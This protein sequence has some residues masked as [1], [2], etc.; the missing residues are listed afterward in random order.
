MRRAASSTAPPPACP[1]RR[2]RAP[3]PPR[4]PASA[5]STT[6]AGGKGP[7][8]R[9]ARPPVWPR[10]AEPGS[11]AS[12][13]GAARA[14]GGDRCGAALVP[15]RSRSQVRQAPAV[16]ARR[17]S[18]SSVSAGRSR[19]RAA[20]ARAV[21]SSRAQFGGDDRGW[22]KAWVMGS[23]SR[24]WRASGGAA[25]CAAARRPAPRRRSAPCR[26][27]IQGDAVAEQQ[28]AVEEGR[29]MPR[30]RRL[31]TTSKAPVP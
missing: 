22:T 31:A 30:Y 20:R 26:P 6:A 29:A 14:A 19:S 2:R 9:S 4:G 7:A 5:A 23:A 11:G 18:P 27:A 15:H 10:D 13:G 25:G 24:D 17:R 1:G 21:A 12:E 16:P 3:P 8:W 28:H